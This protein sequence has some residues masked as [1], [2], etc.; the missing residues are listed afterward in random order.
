MAKLKQSRIELENQ[1]KEQIGFLITSCKLYD[2]GRHAEAKRLASTLRIL[3]HETKKSRSL[4]GQLYL[5]EIH[6]IDT[7]APYDPEN[8]VSHI[9]LVSIKYEPGWIPWLIPK[10]T[11]TDIMNKSE[12]NKWWSHPVIVS[13]KGVD[14]TIF[15]R[16]NLI[17]NVANT[18]GGAHVDPELEEVYAELSRMNSVGITVIMGDKKYPMLYPEIPSLRQISHEV[19]LTLQEKAPDY[20]IEQYDPN[21]KIEPYGSRIESWPQTEQYSVEFY[22]RPKSI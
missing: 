19:L 6:W 18:D 22:V 16:Q 15:S 7:S 1:L 14:K 21:I 9:S 4:L 17:L 12:F 2:E 20:F 11:T 8:L 13:A 5:R 3:F 10:G